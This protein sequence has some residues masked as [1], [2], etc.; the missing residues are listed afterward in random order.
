[1]IHIAHF[2]KILFKPTETFI[3]N[4]LTTAGCSKSIAVTFKREREKEFPLDIPVV[5]LYRWNLLATTYRRLKEKILRTYLPLKFDQTKTYQNLKKHR[6]QLL[7]AHFGY[8]GAQLLPVKRKTDLPLVTTFYG[9]DV[10]ALAKEKKWIKAYKKLFKIGDLFLVEGPNMKKKLIEIGCPEDKI[11]MQRIAIKTERYPYRDR[12]HKNN[13]E[14]VRILFCGSFREKKGLVYALKAVK[15]AI[16]IYPT[17]EFIIVGDGPQR[18]RIDSV[19][20]ENNM[21]PY[22]KLKG[23]LDH[24]QMI[25]EMDKADLFIHPS[26]TAKNGNSEGGAPT[27]ILE[28]QACGLP[29]LSTTHA[30]I[31]YIVNDKESGLLSAEGDVEQLSQNLIR[32]LQNQSLWSRMGKEGRKQ[33]ENHHEISTESKKLEL[34]YQQLL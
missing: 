4:Y 24:S 23:F 9:E 17:L 31:P 18:E 15:K 13:G 25:A 8:T 3:Y 20:N 26:I 12:Q 28:A 16:Q 19:I 32:L 33:V 27:V 6:T 34:K 22:V 30:D 7:H 5:E 14:T 2:R 21:Q 11:Q 1:M 29:I 10:S